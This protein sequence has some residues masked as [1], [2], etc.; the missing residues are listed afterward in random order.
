MIYMVLC[1]LDWEKKVSGSGRGGGETN[2]FW[3]KMTPE[4]ATPLC[5][6]RHHDSFERTSRCLLQPR[7]LHF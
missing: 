7:S 3:K 2:A 4:E 1:E 6:S 5:G